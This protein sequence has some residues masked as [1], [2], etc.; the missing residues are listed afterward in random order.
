MWQLREIDALPLFISLILSLYLVRG[1]SHILVPAIGPIKNPKKLGKWF[2]LEQFPIRQMMCNSF[3]YL[4][5]NL[6]GENTKRDKNTL[7]RCQSKACV[8][9]AILTN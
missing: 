4:V 2:D 6:L 3:A 7:R 1:P 9:F 5:V 8:G